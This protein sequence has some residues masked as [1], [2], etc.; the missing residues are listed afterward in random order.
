MKTKSNLIIHN[1]ICK[2]PLSNGLLVLV[3]L[4]LLFGTVQCA[5]LPVSGSS[6][7]YDPALAPETRSSYELKIEVDYF[8]G[9]LYPEII[10]AFVF[11]EN[12]FDSRGIK[13]EIDFNSTNNIIPGKGGMG[14]NF[15]SYWREIERKY[16]DNPYT[17][18]YFLICQSGI[19]ALGRAS[20]YGAIIAADIIVGNNVYRHTIMHEIG[21]C[22]GIGWQDDGPTEEVYP[23]EGFMSEAT[24]NANE[25][26]Y[27]EED[28]NSAFSQ[29]ET[30]STNERASARIWNRYSIVGEIYDNTA[31]VMGWINSEYVG[32]ISLK[33]LDGSINGVNIDADG[34]FHFQ[35]EPGNYTLEI[36]SY[37][38][39]LDEYRLVETVFVN[40]TERETYYLGNLTI[41]HAEV[42]PYEIPLDNRMAYLLVAI[43]ILAI[44]SL[45][46]TL[47][48][49]KLKN[50]Q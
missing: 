44:L 39:R 30:N 41:E 11:L 10:E 47:R 34:S 48:Y 43:S 17:H 15:Q 19:D 33:E 28:W 46:F 8:E 16:H 50:R 5:F 40:V 36:P 32:I 14:S 49:Y 20:R 31:D 38:Y 2:T 26:E 27:R 13:T 42:Q 9:L 18:V 4:S 35:A 6:V 12:Y 21:H 1:G 45:A 24:D 3:T 37:E 23:S 29:E 22:I 25:T 7:S